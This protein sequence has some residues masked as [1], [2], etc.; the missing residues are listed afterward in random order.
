MTEEELEEVIANC[1]TLFHMA[2]RGSWE[3]IRERGLLSTSALLDLYGVSGA[4]RE[5]IEST[6][7][8]NSVQLSADGLPTAVVRDQLPMDDKG[9]KRCLPDHL[10]PKDWYNLLNTKVFFWL[11]QDRLHRL[12]GAGAYRDKSHDVIEVDTRSLI[13]AHRGR[14]WFCPMNSG[15]T[16]PFPHPRDDST[17]SRIAEYPYGSWKRKGRAR[18]ERVV[19]LAVDHSVPDL[20]SFVTRV[21]VMRGTEIR[22]V[23]L[24]SD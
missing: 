11:T 5:A 20:I 4:K 13:G 12:T 16:K 23:L 17:F 18:G 9:L 21:V 24:S 15:N 2:E 22:K 1:P 19:E 6:R 8:P 10:T 14:I 3:S 7:R